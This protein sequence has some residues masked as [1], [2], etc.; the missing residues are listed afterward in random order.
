MSA[1]F[2]AAH[3]TGPDW[4]PLVEHCAARVPH[5]AAGA[6]LGI[7]YATDAFA[8]EFDAIVAAL[9]AATGIADWVGTVGFGVV[10]G[11][12]E[13][14]DEPALAVMT[15]MLPRET[16]RLLPP[17]A[18]PGERDALAAWARAHDGAV[19]V[20]HADGD[21]PGL[22]ER[23]AELAEST[24]AYVLGGLGSS[25]SVL[26]QVAGAIGRGALSGLLL[27]PGAVAASGLSQGCSPIGPARRVTAAHDNV[28]ETIDDRPALERLQ[29][30]LEALPDAERDA[31]ARRLHVALPVAGSDTGDYLVRNL[32]GVDPKRGW[33]AIGDTAE[34]GQAIRFVRRDRAAA[35]ADLARMAAAARRRAGTAPAAALY[36]RCV[37]RGPNL[38]GPGARE[39]AILRREIGD[40][41]LVGVFCN[42]EIADARLYGYTGV[43]ALL[44]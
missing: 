12:A 38:F 5:A 31:A 41:P 18:Q 1:R 8:A 36:F 21:E 22:P 19:A 16:F 27:A 7:V 30:D 11:D 20:I 6:T 35:E 34:A 37:A 28:V 3:A 43:L 33:V 26:P 9:R 4:E 40:V 24:G 42:G 10:A 2:A 44:A 32:V 13:H 23:L 39:L 29:D 15:G 14:F 17:T 25:R